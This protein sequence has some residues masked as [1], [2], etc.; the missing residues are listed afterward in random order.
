LCFN[1][2]QNP[3]GVLKM[4]KLRKLVLKALHQSG[5]TEDETKLSDTLEHKVSPP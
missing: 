2:R 1:E 4:R 3:D 5:T